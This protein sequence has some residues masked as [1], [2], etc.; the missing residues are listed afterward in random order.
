MGNFKVLNLIC[1]SLVMLTGFS[2]LA[3]GGHVIYCNQTLKLD[4]AKD[5]NGL[6]YLVCGGGNAYLAFDESSATQDPLDSTP[7]TCHYYAPED[8]PNKGF[9]NVTGDFSQLPALNSVYHFK[10][11]NLVSKEVA[12]EEGVD[13]ITSELTV[14]TSKAPTK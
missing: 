1:A 14:Y 6:V 7:R 8:G 10:F 13:F 5:C 11:F 3:S 2:A 9:M 12:D 4:S